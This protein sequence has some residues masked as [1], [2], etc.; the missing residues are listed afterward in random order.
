MVPG[1]VARITRGAR[2]RT[3]EGAL[4][5]FLIVK[6]NYMNA[7]IPISKV[8]NHDPNLCGYEILMQKP[9]NMAVY[10]IYG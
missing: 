3:G 7:S 2:L 6:V 4:L 1:Q 8:V 9:H 10:N 5:W